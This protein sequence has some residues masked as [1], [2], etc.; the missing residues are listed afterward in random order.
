MELLESAEKEEMDVPPRLECAEA[1]K[2]IKVEKR[3]LS[4]E[5]SESEGS[6][7]GSVDMDKRERKRKRLNVEEATLTFLKYLDEKSQ[8][9]MIRVWEN[10]AGVKL[11][12]CRCGSRKPVPDLSK[13]KRHVESHQEKVFQCPICNKT[14]GK[15]LQLNGHMKVHKPKAFG[16]PSAKIPDVTPQSFS[17]TSVSIWS[18]NW[19]YPTLPMNPMMSI[20]YGFIPNPLYMFPLPQYHGIP[21]SSSVSPV[22]TQTS[23][24]IYTGM[25]P[26][27]PPRP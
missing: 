15:H 12:D 8:D 2:K 17:A 9:S 13:I 27:L 25:L 10:G 1:S 26:S 20:P 18:N 6:R 14:F 5:S 23:Q 7:L 22:S 21:Q 4:A 11:Y 24:L 3:G 19:Q 16:A